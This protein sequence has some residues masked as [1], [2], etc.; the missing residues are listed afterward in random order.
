MQTDFL[1][2]IWAMVQD[3]FVNVDPVSGGI[4]IVVALLAGLIL[5]RYLSGIISVT[6]GALIAYAAA[7]FAKLV[8]L[9]GREIQ[10]LA[11]SWWSGMLNMR[12]GEVLVYFVAF[13]VVITVVYILKTAFFA[14][15]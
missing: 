2:D 13:L 7:R 15:R 8:L 4:A 12:F 10:P 6:I 1:G 9:D 5:Q 3:V 14:N 11:E